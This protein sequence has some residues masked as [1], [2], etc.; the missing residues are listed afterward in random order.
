MTDVPILYIQG[1]NDKE[2]NMNSTERYEQIKAERKSQVEA[3]YAVTF[4]V[5]DTDNRTMT[6]LWFAMVAERKAEQV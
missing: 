6:E 3:Q 2:N 5:E 1:K 4:T